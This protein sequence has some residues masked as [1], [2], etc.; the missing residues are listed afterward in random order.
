MNAPLLQRRSGI[1]PERWRQIDARV[2]NDDGAVVRVRHGLSHLGW[3]ARLVDLQRRGVV[4]RAMAEAGAQLHRDYYRSG[5]DPTASRPDTGGSGGGGGAVP[6]CGPR[7]PQ[8][9]A[10]IRAIS[11]IES[12]ERGVVIAVCLQDMGTR[13]WWTWHRGVPKNKASD[14]LRLGLLRL[15]EHYGA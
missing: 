10:A 7:Y 12:P 3:P 8:Y 14:L 15:V 11:E 9:T 6:G 4:T 13:E 1:S 5:L 2:V